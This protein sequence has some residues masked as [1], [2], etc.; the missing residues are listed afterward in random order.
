MFS[1]NAIAALNKSVDSGAAAYGPISVQV[2]P[3]GICNAE[4][5]FC[6]IHSRSIPLE[7][8]QKHA[9]RLISK[10][11]FL[12][13]DLYRKFIDDL[14]ELGLTKRIQFT[15][16]GDP[17]VH[18]KFVEMVSYA[19][20]QLPNCALIV[21][22]NG[23]YLKKYCREL[24][25]SAVD[26]ISVSLNAGKS[27][28]WIELNRKGTE[29]EFH[30]II[31]A[32]ED[33]SRLKN[34]GKPRLT[35]TAVLNKYNYDDLR[36]LLTIAQ[37]SKSEAL[38]FIRMMVIDLGG[39]Q[40]NRD[41][42]CSPDQFR[43]FE[44][45][46]E[47]LKTNANGMYLSLCGIGPD[48]G[49]LDTT[50]VAATVPCYAGWTFTMLYPDGSIYPCCM[51]A[52]SLGNVTKERFKDIWR[53]DLY[54]SFRTR[55]MRIPQLGVL[56]GCSCNECGYYYENQEYHRLLLQRKTEEISLG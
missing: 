11:K 12:D 6:P 10:G 53:S 15:G 51:C 3:S 49:S 1:E 14:K 48:D 16:L 26:E 47:E 33:L 32:I 40:S 52:T 9:S 41:H 44:Q 31:K 55:V 23:I 21:V 2:L 42:L 22:T 18:P 46:L 8:K 54:S 24:V 34:P 37:R 35:I 4:C 28:T 5:I 25:D 36:E 39:F 29:E 50:G 30:A 43:K 45:T 56:P 13:I 38:T 17:L 20:A 19:R 27:K 7:L